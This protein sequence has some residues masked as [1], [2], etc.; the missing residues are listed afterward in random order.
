MR[1][2]L[3]VEWQTPLIFV[4]LVAFCAGAALGIAACLGQLFRLRREIAAL[5]KGPPGGGGER[6]TAGQSGLENELQV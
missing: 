2:Y 6:A 4:L 3:G 5:R 1:Y